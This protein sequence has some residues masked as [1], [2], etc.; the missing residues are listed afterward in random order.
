MACRA[1]SRSLS[2]VVQFRFEFRALDPSN[3]AHL[4]KDLMELGGATPEIEDS[5]F[6]LKNRADDEH[7][8]SRAQA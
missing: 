1:P 6:R 2:N 5:C 7:L 4:T 8:W 3:S